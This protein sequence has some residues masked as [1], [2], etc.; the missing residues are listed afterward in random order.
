MDKEWWPMLHFG[1]VNLWTSI[2]VVMFYSS[3]EEQEEMIWQ[4]YV[5]PRVPVVREKSM[6]IPRRAQ[7]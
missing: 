6:D 3:R 4:G 7:S 5:S 1:P 2:P